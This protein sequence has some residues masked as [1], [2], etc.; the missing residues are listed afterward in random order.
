VRNIVLSWVGTLALGAQHGGIFRMVIREGMLLA[1]AGVAIGLAGAFGLTR[2][3]QSLLFGVRATDPLTFSAVAALLAGVALAASIR[4]RA[5][6]R[7]W[8]RWWRCAMTDSR[9]YGMAGEVKT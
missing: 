3:L 9:L 8:A 4:R 6:R 7:E 5:A 2:F 1:L